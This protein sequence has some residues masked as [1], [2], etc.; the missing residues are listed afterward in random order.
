MTRRQTRKAWRI[1][2]GPISAAFM[3]GMDLGLGLSTRINFVSYSILASGC[4]LI[5]DPAHGAII[6]SGYGLGRTLVI[7]S[8]PLIVHAASHQRRGLALGHALFQS[9]SAWHR[10]HACTLCM[11]GLF[12]L[13]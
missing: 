11:V 5:A 1:R 8:G 3:W 10:L 13:L 7:A 6:I 9:E 12:M 4:F 2:H